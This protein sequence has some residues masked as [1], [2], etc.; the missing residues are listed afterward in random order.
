[1]SMLNSITMDEIQR[2]QVL[3][4]DDLERSVKVLPSAEVKPSLIHTQRLEKRCFEI[5]IDLLRW[6]LFD[7][8]QRDLLFWHEVARIQSR[9]IA[10]NQSDLIVLSLGLG[11]AL[12]NTAMQNVLLLSGSLLIAG[13]A[14]Y[15]LYQRNRG[16]RSLKKAAAADQSAIALAVQSGYAFTNAYRSL[17]SALTMLAKQAPSNHQ[18]VRY[19]ARQNVLEI[20]AR[21]HDGCADTGSVDSDDRA[22]PSRPRLS[23]SSQ[24][25]SKASAARERHFSV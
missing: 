24:S 23:L 11:A 9:A 17:H 25:K 2:L 8:A 18:R 14:G 21:H 3:L 15:Q 4:P 10:H 16:E 7:H 13:L 22:R 19:E 20:F 12:V 6:Q 1:M 5:Q